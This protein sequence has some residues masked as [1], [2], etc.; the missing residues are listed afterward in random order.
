MSREIRLR[1][2]AAHRWL[3]CTAFPALDARLDLPETSGRA[4]REGT[5]LHAHMENYLETGAVLPKCTDDHSHA[6]GHAYA[7]FRRYVDPTCSL[8]LTV[9]EPIVLEPPGGV[10]VR[11]TADLIGWD[12]TRKRLVVLDWK[13]GTRTRVTAQGNPQ[14]LLYAAGAYKRMIQRGRQPETVEAWIVQPRIEG[15]EPECWT[16]PIP[17]LISEMIEV[18]RTIKMIKGGHVKYEPTEKNCRWCPVQKYCPE[19]VSATPAPPVLDEVAK[20]FETP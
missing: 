18:G 13:F 10:P 20:Y 1:P 16:L 6:V 17:D 19:Y 12:R 7:Q 4:A 14:L 2:S 8:S 5:R 9:E 15:A 11:G 3:S